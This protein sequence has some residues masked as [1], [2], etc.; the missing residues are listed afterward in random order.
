MRGRMIPPWIARPTMT[1]TMY[2]PSCRATISKS[3]MAATLPQ[4]REAMPT[5][6]Y[7]R[8]RAVNR[9]P[10]GVQASSQNELHEKERKEMS[11]RLFESRSG[12][13]RNSIPNT[14]PI[15]TPLIRLGSDA[16]ASLGCH[17]DRLGP[18]LPSQSCPKAYYCSSRAWKKLQ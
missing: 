6:E 10:K 11:I 17:G 4:I 18:P 5:G 2:I 3:P 8:H 7:L 14:D 15:I 13:Y 16:L 12:M 9:P 1:V